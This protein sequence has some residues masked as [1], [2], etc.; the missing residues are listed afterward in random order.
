MLPRK[1]PE[2]P[3][4]LM[5]IAFLPLQALIAV[6]VLNRILEYR[7]KQIRLEKLN[8]VI[9]AFFSEAGTHIL[10][11][12]SDM[13]SKLSDL[14]KDLSINSDW[15]PQQFDTAT[16][17]LQAHPFK[18]AVKSENVLYLK[19]F[20]LRQRE[21]LLRLLEN[22]MVLE[23]ETF[24]ELLRSVFH[25]IEELAAR[26]NTTSLPEPDMRHLQIDIERIY[27]LMVSQWVAYMRYLGQNYPF[28]FSFALR[29]N[30]FDTNASPIIFKQ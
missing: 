13:D 2:K 24:T 4:E 15:T 28:L 17:K 19:E 7:D 21:F 23:H 22:P 14:K 25:L 9:G 10:T 26:P 1:K 27:K 6:L 16:R 11:Y 29:T 3:R 20:L 5:D 12:V 8:M 18:V 30:P